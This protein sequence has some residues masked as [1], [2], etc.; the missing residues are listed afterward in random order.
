MS[1]AIGISNMSREEYHLRNSKGW[2]VPVGGAFAFDQPNYFVGKP[3]KNPK[4]DTIYIGDDRQI[5]LIKDG[6]EIDLFETIKDL[7]KRLDMFEL[8]IKYMPDGQGYDD[9]KNNFETIKEEW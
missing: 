7:K 2:A 9:A 5:I 8:E 4:P 3:P 6:E 1:V